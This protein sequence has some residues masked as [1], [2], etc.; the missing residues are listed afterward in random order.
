[1]QWPTSKVLSGFSFCQGTHRD[2]GA[3]LTD[4]VGARDGHGEA[5][6]GG[7]RVWTSGGSASGGRGPGVSDLPG[8]A[9]VE[10]PRTRVVG[11]CK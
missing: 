9:V 8:G 3:D 4:V 10:V 1:M 5:A 11:T 2:I 6:R 7:E